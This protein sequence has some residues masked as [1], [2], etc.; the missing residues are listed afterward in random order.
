MSSKNAT[1]VIVALP[2][3]SLKLIASGGP[4]GSH[5]CLARLSHLR[6]P[7]R[8]SPRV[9]ACSGKLH[10]HRCGLIAE[11][12]DDE[13]N[14]GVLLDAESHKTGRDAVDDHLLGLPAGVGK[15]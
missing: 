4:H 11:I 14:V 15:V 6:P 5:E 1:P 8:G 3:S 12:G 7:F 10:D 9:A 2:L 13:M